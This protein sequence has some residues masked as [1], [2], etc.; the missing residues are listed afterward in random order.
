M[1]NRT[2]L[3]IVDDGP[4]GALERLIGQAMPDALALVSS[5][6]PRP[7]GLR[8][9]V[10]VSTARIRAMLPQDGEVHLRLTSDPSWT[11][12]PIHAQALAELLPPADT[13]TNALFVIAE[14]LGIEHPVVS[15]TDSTIQAWLRARR[16]M[17]SL[18]LDHARNA[19]HEVT[20]AWP[21]WGPGWAL[22]DEVYTGLGLFEVALACRDRAGEPPVQVPPRRAMLRLVG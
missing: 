21:S 3:L 19:I 11:P 14:L 15:T 18:N 17:R 16:A 13:D 6:R 9:G 1:P 5:P 2:R 4:S 7:A 10:W 22:A 12:E 20:R 8:R